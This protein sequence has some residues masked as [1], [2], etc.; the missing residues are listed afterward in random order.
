MP[1]RSF[2]FYANL[3]PEVIQAGASMRFPALLLS[4]AMGSP[5]LRKQAAKVK[6]SGARL[7]ADNGNASAIFA[8][9]GVFAAEGERL[10]A[11]W[12]KASPAA[13][14]GKLRADYRE[15]ASIVRAACLAR[16]TD[17]DAGAMLAT[18]TT[19]KPSAFICHEDFTSPVLLALNVDPERLGYEK[20]FYVGQQMFGVDQ[21]V[22]T[23][24]GVNG[25][26]EGMPYATLHGVD[27]D[28]AY[29]AGFYAGLE[30]GVTAIATGI[31]GF[32]NDQAFI[33]SYELRGERISVAGGK[34]VP[35]RYLRA[36]QVAVGLRDG[37]RDAAGHAPH[38]HA[39][40]LGA[41]I[42]LPLLALALDD[43]PALSVDSTAPIKNA[44]MGKVMVDDPAYSNDSIEEIANA[45]LLEGF[46][47]THRCAFCKAFL[48][49]HPF[50][51]DDAIAY[52]KKKLGGRRVRKDDLA[53][54][55]GVGRFLPL[56]YDL[57]A[58]AGDSL[59]KELHQARVGHNHAVML[60]LA[61]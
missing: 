9:I 24:S 57:S 26:Y 51:Y 48:A 23:V 19:F 2:H 40:G 47:W 5:T 50:R 43:V 33:S 18:Q 3:A 44:N 39:L 56:L 54:K 10:D 12:R 14:A 21:A 30:K 4:I 36:L 41:P 58:L 32:M 53:R 7:M 28:T 1:K 38:F 31:A 22:R 17:A 6:A 25:P 37:F 11:A 60:D 42:M 8:L 52:H 49:K 59:R 35:R 55:D 20:S 15:F 27:Y 45:M 34:T 16:I 61:A 13:R 46:R 29:D